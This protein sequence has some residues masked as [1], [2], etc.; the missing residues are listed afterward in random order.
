MVLFLLSPFVMVL[1]LRVLEYAMRYTV[2]LV[3]DL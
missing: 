3:G 2:R 1:F